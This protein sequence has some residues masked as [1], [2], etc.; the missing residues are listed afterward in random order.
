MLMGLLLLRIVSEALRQRVLRCSLN[1]TGWL[2]QA[3]TLMEITTQLVNDIEHGYSYI[4]DSLSTI[5]P[6]YILKITKLQCN[7]PL[8]GFPLPHSPPLYKCLWF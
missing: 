1:A 2:I 3:A 5:E 6:S 4:Y 7:L 8:R